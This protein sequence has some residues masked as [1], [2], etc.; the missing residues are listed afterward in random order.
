VS[1]P[2]GRKEPR[3]ALPA[4]EVARK[5]DSGG[6]PG[7]RSLPG[8]DEARGTC[9]RRRST[10]GE[11]EGAMPAQDDPPKGAVGSTRGASG[12]RAGLPRAAAEAREPESAYS[13]PT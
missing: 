5:K 10:A 7:R 13:R 2:T 11:C 9:R 6:P 12:G 4:S 3:S 8:P 1:R